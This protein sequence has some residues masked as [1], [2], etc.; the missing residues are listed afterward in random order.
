[1]HN[2][3]KNNENFKV[4]TSAKCGHLPEYSHFAPRTVTVDSEEQWGLE[5]LHAAVKSRFSSPLLVQSL[6]SW[7]VFRLTV[8]GSAQ[9]RSS[10]AYSSTQLDSISWI[11]EQWSLNSFISLAMKF[12]EEFKSHIGNRILLFLKKKQNKTVK[13]ICVL[14][15]YQFPGWENAVW[16]TNATGGQ[17]L[18]CEWFSSAYIME[19]P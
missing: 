17:S 8:R 16:E 19:K 1:M 10:P 15:R 2:Y 9:H 6:Y 3:R 18:C 5:G 4:K 14:G 7:A 13:W 11:T 12:G